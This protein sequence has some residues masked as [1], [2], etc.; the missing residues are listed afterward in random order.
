MACYVNIYKIN[1]VLHVVRIFYCQ[2]RIRYLT[3]KLLNID[4]NKIL[5]IRNNFTNYII[6]THK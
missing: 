2:I 1:H 6:N 3:R 5:C 4:L